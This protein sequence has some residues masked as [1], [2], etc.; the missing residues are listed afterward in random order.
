MGAPAL[1]KLIAALGYWGGG[2]TFL[3][4]CS[5][6][7]P[8]LST[9]SSG[10]A[11]SKGSHLSPVVSS[12]TCICPLLTPKFPTRPGVPC[13]PLL[14]LRGP[15]LASPARDRG[16]LGISHGVAAPPA[17]APRCL[18]LRLGPFRHCRIRPPP[19]SPR[20]LRAHRVD[21][22]SRSAPSGG[23]DLALPLAGTPRG[24]G[25]AEP[26]TGS[27]S[28]APRSSWS[29]WGPGSGPS[30]NPGLTGLR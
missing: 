8:A 29:Q 15:S 7:A 30:S 16:L 9:H 2:W 13:L 26:A 20:G 22:R 23:P 4:G 27:H 24:A 11:V 25:D 17:T 12:S 6:L 21:Q 14:V 5:W 18:S 1:P 3:Y 19:Q 28:R 10:G